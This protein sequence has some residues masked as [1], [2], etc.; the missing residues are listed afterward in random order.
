MGKLRRSRFAK[1]IS[2][3][4]ILVLSVSIVAN[5]AGA[6][7]L[8]EENLFYANR[9]QLQQKVHSHLYN[10]T[11]SDLMSYLRLMENAYC[12]NDI[13]SNY[14]DSEIDLYA[15]KYSSDKSNINFYITDENGNILLAN[16]NK[17][18]D[19]IYSFS[20]VYSTDTKYYDWYKLGNTSDDGIN[21]SVIA[22]PTTFL[23]SSENSD[24]IDINESD[25]TTTVKT[26]PV[27]SISDKYDVDKSSVQNTYT[28]NNTEIDYYYTGSVD[29]YIFEHCRSFAKNLTYDIS[30]ITFYQDEFYYYDEGITNNYSDNDSSSPERIITFTL[31]SDN[32]EAE[33][34]YRYSGTLS[35]SEFT[36]RLSYSALILQNSESEQI[37]LEY[38]QNSRLQIRVTVEVP[39]SCTVNDIY[40]YAESFV[41]LA[42]SYK[43]NIIT[44]SVIELLLFIL[45][46]VFI[47]YSAGYIPN[48]E[49]PV[50]RGLHAIPTDILYL[51]GAIGLVI[52][53]IMMTNFDMLFFIVGA[54]LAA[55]IILTIIYISVVKLRTNTFKKNTLIGTVYF[56][57]KSAAKT[58]NE[59]TGS[60]I[61]I[62][63][64]ICLL[65]FIAIIEAFCVIFFDMHS[66]FVAGAIILIR[67]SEIPVIT[68]LLIAL[69]ALH[70]GAKQISSGD[71]NYRITNPLLFGALKQHADNLNNINDAVNTAVEQ[72][73]K[74]EN[75]KT[76]LITNVSHDLKTP[77]TSIVNY[78]D[79]LK[80]EKI[81]NVKA[82]E[83]I[84]V[85]DRQAE[86]LKKLTID[87]VEASKAA[88]GNIDV[89]L[90][91][92]VL[93]VI[94][95]QTSG[96]YMERLEELNLSIVQDIPDKD[97]IISTDGRLLWR[98]IENLMNNICKY[99]M[100]GTRVYISLS[101]NETEAI[102]SFRNISKNK[103][104]ISPEELTE[105]FVRGDQSR[106]TE[107]SGLGLSIANSLTAI[108]GGKLTLSI[109]GDLFKATIS[110]PKNNINNASDFNI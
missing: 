92:T 109:D 3:F 6:F 98:V 51:I 45:C 44:I 36:S 108:I 57:T 74:S 27:Q 107:G 11:A 81:D 14:H 17:L 99:S 85:I 31:Y 10:Y 102:I 34:I 104:N 83:Y 20:S 9:I 95:L 4:L 89:K 13:Y 12:N 16:K 65:I 2:G 73:L 30:S 79:L 37:S 62:F 100:P 69:T 26:E 15:S 94:L 63:L 32:K 5:V 110:F 25:E 68:I 105:R 67:I 23:D 53:F 93:N 82:V 39:Y 91:P 61:K 106:N 43:D 52:C 101:E 55:L 24:A 71:M 8:Y 72:R 80:K 58:L 35:F 59:N 87:I 41:V 103:L 88:T 19:E 96:E 38:K 86:R 97:I 7:I 84:K 77:L 78:V 64:I 47:F 28:G 75:M 18:S 66:T 90:E 60:K 54:I 76:E 46:F 33:I 49:K 22:V 21:E 1:F 42:E 40:K 70:K 48:K 56:L 29:S 50:A